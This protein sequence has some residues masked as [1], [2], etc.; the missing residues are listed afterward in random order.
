MF[1]YSFVAAADHEKKRNKE[2]DSAKGES[3]LKK[4]GVW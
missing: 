4:S 2:Q 3:I 1:P